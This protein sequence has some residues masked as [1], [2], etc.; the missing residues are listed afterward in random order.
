MSTDDLERAAEI[1][2]RAGLL[3]KTGLTSDGVDLLWEYDSAATVVPGTALAA[4]VAPGTALDDV[5]DEV[6]KALGR[7]AI[8]REENADLLA[9]IVGAVCG[10]LKIPGAAECVGHDW[11][12]IEA[13][14]R[15]LHAALQ[16]SPNRT[17][18][19]AALP[20]D[21]QRADSLMT[22]IE[23][24]LSTARAHVSENARGRF[25]ILSKAEV[26]TEDVRLRGLL[27]NLRVREVCGRG[28]A[29]TVA[30]ALLAVRRRERGD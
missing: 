29:L 20:P 23:Q 30:A 21:Y 18:A 26:P 28:D 11:A 16:A 3:T 14:L 19:Q 17:D 15:R 2:R 27:E 12:P 22:P 24:L 25:K 10:R 1:L 4:A 7:T 13:E 6:R 9:Q 8:H 5:L